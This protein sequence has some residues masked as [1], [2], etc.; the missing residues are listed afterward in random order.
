MY[1]RIIATFTYRLVAE[2]SLGTHLNSDNLCN[3]Q[4]LST[5]QSPMNIFLG[6]MKIRSDPILA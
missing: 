1:S 5:L 2:V 4:M 3:P 6:S